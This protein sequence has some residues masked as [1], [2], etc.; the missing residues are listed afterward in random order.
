MRMIVLMLLLLS[1]VIFSVE[2]SL[3]AFEYSNGPSMF[4]KF[5]IRKEIGPFE[6]GLTHWIFWRAY[7]F[8][9]YNFPERITPFSWES[10]GGWW[11]VYVKLNF[12]KSFYFKFLHRSEHNFDGCRYL[13][14][15]WY[16]FF[17]FGFV[18]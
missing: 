4:A 15:H 6:L 9:F 10:R 8:G 3:G 17:E 1:V 11:D 7:D 2:F 12:T 16:N 14:I 18:W 5:E 13:N